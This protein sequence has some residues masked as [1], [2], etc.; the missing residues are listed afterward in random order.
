MPDGLSAARARFAAAARQGRTG[1]AVSGGADS[2][3]LL[4]LA[5]EA[6]AREGATD[7]FIVYSVDHALRPEAAAEAAMVVATARKLGFDGRVL[8]WEGDK[9]ATG[10]QAA[11]RAARYRIIGEAMRR[12]GAEVLFTAHHRRDQAETVLMRLAHGSGIDGLSGMREEQ[13]VAGVR[14]VRP[15]LDVA[16]E[17]LRALVGAAGLHPVEDPSNADRAYERVRWRQALPQ[18]GELGL[19]ADRLATFASR[20]RL[21]AELVE[22]AASG[23]HAQLVEPIDG[24]GLALSRAGLVALNPLVQVALLGQMLQQVSGDP[25]PVPLAALERI[26][27][28]IASGELQSA[29]TLHGCIV[30]AR[31]K[32]IKLRREGARRSRTQEQGEKPP[33]AKTAP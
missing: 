9:P 12:D 20:M 14:V 17:P 31:G 10:I 11:A 26:C 3:A 27:R 16:P 13:L 22:D 6:V 15:L 21:A 29:T 32:L 8:R 5:Q 33:N 25:G 18:L 30:S 19:T 23:A 24:G 4:V 28:H 1:L 2:L 7:C